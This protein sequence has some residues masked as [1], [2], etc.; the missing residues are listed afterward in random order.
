[1]RSTFSIIWILG[2][3]LV[4]AALDTRPDPPA[5]NPGPALS[6]F[7]QPHDSTCETALLTAVPLVSAPALAFRVAAV[8][9][10]KH[11]RPGDRV[12][13]TGQAADPSP[14]CRA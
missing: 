5:L 10:G 1:M 11:E 14:P 7:V 8:D 4:F 9:I 6:K 12:L 13:L 2:A 3:F